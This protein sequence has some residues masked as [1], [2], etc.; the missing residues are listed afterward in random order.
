MLCQLLS[1]SLLVFCCHVEVWRCG[2]GGLWSVHVVGGLLNREL[3][4]CTD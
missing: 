2:G 3:A 1:C 4:G